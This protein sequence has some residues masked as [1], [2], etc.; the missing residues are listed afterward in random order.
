MTGNALDRTVTPETLV[1]M[2]QAGN[3]TAPTPVST[4]I[5][6]HAATDVRVAWA[7]FTD[8]TRFSVHLRTA[9][10]AESIR[11]ELEFRAMRWTVHRV[12]LPNELL[13]RAGS[14]T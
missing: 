7:F 11:V 10:A 13:E 1:S 12:W 4:Q 9:A 5:P 3:A 2:S 6:S 8:P 14:G